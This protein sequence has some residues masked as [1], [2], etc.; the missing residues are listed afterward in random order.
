MPDFDLEKIKQL[1]G[2]LLLVLRELLRQRQAT[3]AAQRLGLSPSAISHALGRLRELFGDPLFVR[4]PYGLTPTRHALELAPRVEALLAAMHDAIGL[5]SSFAPQDTTRSF[6]IAA[7]DHLTTLLAPALLGCF[8]KNAPNARFAFSQRLGED[9]QHALLRDELDIALGRFAQRD[10]RVV[11][12]PLFED[13]YCLV[14]RKD[15]PKLK[16]GRL[17]AAL[18]TRLDQ[19]QV[20]VSGDLRAP[21]FHAELAGAL[22]RRTVAAVPRFMIAF[23]VVAESDAVTIAPMRLARRHARAFGLRL[24]DLPFELAPIRVVLA[25]RAQPDRG[26]MFLIEQLRLA[27]G[28]TA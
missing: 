15:H 28:Q 16:R 5:P 6:R 13:R 8:N 21:E 1:D 24:H 3:L 2:S 23:S 10:E 25:M 26:V 7:P 27:A 14:A 11:M 18:F 17:N 19:L 9:A 20:S 12:E 22:P 4:R